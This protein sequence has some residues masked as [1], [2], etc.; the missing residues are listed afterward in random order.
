MTWEQVSA[1]LDRMLCETRKMIA[2][3]NKLIARTN[4]R[5]ESMRKYNE[6]KK[7]KQVFLPER[8]AA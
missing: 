5:I 8:K 6:A 2:D 1:E 7:E 3:T 4:A